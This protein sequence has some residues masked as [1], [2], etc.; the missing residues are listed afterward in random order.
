MNRNE[1]EI[2]FVLNDISIRRTEISLLKTEFLT[3]Q[4][5]VV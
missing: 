3:D 4:G 1:N 5:A 2:R